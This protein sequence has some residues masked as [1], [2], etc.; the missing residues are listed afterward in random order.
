MQ[1]IFGYVGSWETEG[2]EYNE[3]L[4]LE[5][6]QLFWEKYTQLIDEASQ[7]HSQ[8]QGSLEKSRQNSAISR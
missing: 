7:S 4:L 3:V 2:N 6:E 5:S 8:N 1:E